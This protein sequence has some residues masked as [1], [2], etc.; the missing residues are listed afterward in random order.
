[1]G[2]TNAGVHMDCML[3][4]SVDGEPYGTND[5]G[6][7]PWGMK[8]WSC[9]QTT[10]VAMHTL[11]FDDPD[12]DGWGLYNRVFTRHHVDE[13]GFGYGQGGDFTYGETQPLR[14]S[15]FAT[16]RAETIFRFLHTAAENV[17]ADDLMLLTSTVLE[18]VVSS[19]LIPPGQAGHFPVGPALTRDGLDA[20][21]TAFVQTLLPTEQQRLAEARAWLVV[22]QRVQPLYQEVLALGRALPQQATIAMLN[23]ALSTAEPGG[24]IEV[25]TQFFTNLEAL[26]I[27]QEVIPPMAKLYLWVHENLARRLLPAAANEPLKEVV[28]AR[29]RE[30]SPQEERRIKTILDDGV[31]AFNVFREFCNGS[32]APRFSSFK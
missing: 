6:M 4:F 3:Q 11:L 30:L 20:A 23:E 25:L 22:A 16:H 21:E 10:A 15:N 31:K 14:V 27:I 7:S 9:A 12:N 13:T 8:F 19:S 28:M 32:T 17:S 26:A 2:D 1:M 5:M 24:H 29:A 18:R